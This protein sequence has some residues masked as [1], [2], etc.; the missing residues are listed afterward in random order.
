[1]A[2]VFAASLHLGLGLVDAEALDREWG[3]RRPVGAQA[4]EEHRQVAA[5]ERRVETAGAVHERCQ[6]ELDNTTSVGSNRAGACLGLWR[7]RRSR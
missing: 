6:G 4:V 7:G 2:E 3:Q 5:V 1:M